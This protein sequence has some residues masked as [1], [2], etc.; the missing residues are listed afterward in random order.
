MFLGKVKYLLTIRYT[1]YVKGKHIFFL[2][3]EICRVVIHILS[4]ITTYP[5][6]LQ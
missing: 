6:Q 3:Y 1:D 2:Y 5:V 4:K